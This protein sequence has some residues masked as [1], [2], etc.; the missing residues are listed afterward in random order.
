[1]GCKQWKQLGTSTFGPGTANEHIVQWLLKKLW[2]GD[3]ILEDEE[4]SGR[5][6]EVENDQ[7]KAVTEADPLTTIHY[8]AEELN[9]DHSKVHQHLKQI[10]K[11]KKLSKWMPHELTENK[12]IFVIKFHLLLCN[13]EPFLDQIV[14][15]D[16]KW[17]LYNW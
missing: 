9:I 13:K 12:K 11:V 10:G 6:L 1:M 16:E 8:V 15:C 7:L 4:L 17:I 5:P 14:T 2:K 3:E